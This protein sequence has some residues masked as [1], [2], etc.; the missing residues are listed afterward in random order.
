[1]A[2]VLIS[3]GKDY[4][5]TD[6]VNGLAK[7]EVLPGICDEI[8]MYRCTLKAG[9]A[10][11]PAVYAFEEKMQIFLFVAGNGYITTGAEAY[12]I[13]DR[14]VFV[15]NFNKDEVLIKAGTKDL[16]YIHIVGEMTRW[17]QERMKIDHIVLPR[18]RLLKDSWE[19]T[20]GFT[21]DAG[22]NIKSHMVLEHE[23]LGRYSMGW[24]CGEGP[25]FIGTHVHEDLLQWY[26]NMPGSSFTYHAAEETVN[27][28]SGDI[29]F[30]EIGSPHGS[31]ALEGQC[32]D[33]VWFELAINGYI[34]DDDILKEHKENE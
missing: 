1:M 8:A 33:Y 25:T 28:E 13:D 2:K 10:W 31:E 27:V 19:Y 34:H 16:T 32:I 15:P 7:E 18:F 5:P 12:R 3:R 4:N 22:S 23:Y 30:T 11:K 24:N 26:L 21:G 29:T 20:E 6:Y 14:A 9:A 17:D